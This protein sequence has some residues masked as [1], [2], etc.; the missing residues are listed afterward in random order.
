MALYFG[1]SQLFVPVLELGE[2]LQ[3][4][5]TDTARLYTP[6]EQLVVVGSGRGRCPSVS[7]TT[8]WGHAVMREVVS[9]AVKVCLYDAIGAFPGRR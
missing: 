1:P 6:D 3:K 7:I 2:A 5:R 9:D 4:D 8:I